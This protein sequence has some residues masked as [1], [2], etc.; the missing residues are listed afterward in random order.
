VTCSTLAFAHFSST[1]N[2]NKYPL[3]SPQVFFTTK[4][5]N[6]GRSSV[7]FVVGICY[8]LRD[9]KRSFDQMTNARF[10]SGKRIMDQWRSL[11]LNETEVKKQRRLKKSGTP[12]PFLLNGIV[13]LTQNLKKIYTVSPFN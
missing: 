11:D 4:Y 8:V 5:N 2:V 9:P 12:L 1:W 6:I 13:Q 3:A 10:V 7:I